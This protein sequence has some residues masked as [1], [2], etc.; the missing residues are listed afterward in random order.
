MARAN[1]PRYMHDAE[2]HNRR[3]ARRVVPWIMERLGPKT[4]LDV[5]C[6][7]GT[8][9]A[10]FLEHG[11]DVLGLDGGYVPT[12]LLDIPRDRFR[13]VD[14]EGEVAPPGRFD[15]AICLEVAEHLSERAAP[16]LVALLTSAADAILFSA[17]VPGQG[18]DNHLNERWPAYWQG[19][20]RAR[21]FDFEDE[22]RWAFWDDDEVDW[23]YRQNMFLVR[24]G[25]SADVAARSVVHPALLAKKMRAVEDFYAGRVPLR[26]AAIVLARALGRSLRGR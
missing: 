23:W 22:V 3:A 20:F 17:A 21:G 10:V 18:G 13:E 11:C 7:L 14:L 6:G 8:W 2:T 1:R 9:A 4:V 12:D 5:G 25:A 26:T 24:R 16:G 15:L 19:L